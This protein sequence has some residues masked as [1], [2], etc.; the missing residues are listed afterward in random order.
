[1][2]TAAP[3]VPVKPPVSTGGG[4][5]QQCLYSFVL[6]PETMMPLDPSGRAKPR[7]SSRGGLTPGNAPCSLSRISHSELLPHMPEAIRAAG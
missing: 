1:M 3:G 2:K 4:I 7:S 5:G 6:I